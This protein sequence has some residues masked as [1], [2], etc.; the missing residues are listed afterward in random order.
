MLPVGAKDSKIKSEPSVKDG[1]RSIK[2][3][4]DLV[5][6]YQKRE[7]PWLYSRRA[8]ERCCIPGM[9]P[10]CLHLLASTLTPA[11]EVWLTEEGYRCHR[12]GCILPATAVLSLQTNACSVTLLCCNAIDSSFLSP[13]HSLPLSAAPPSAHFPTFTCTHSHTQTHTLTHEE[14]EYKWGVFLKDMIVLLNDFFF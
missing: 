6:W 9:C 12:C 8:L 10:E 4:K 11:V 5:L 2:R 3:Q 1:R 14:P 13:I 7:K